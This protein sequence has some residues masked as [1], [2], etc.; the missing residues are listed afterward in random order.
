MAF[1]DKLCE[2]DD[3]TVERSLYNEYWYVMYIL[4]LYLKL[5]TPKWRLLSGVQFFASCSLMMYFAIIMIITA[6][7]LKENMMGM[8]QGLHYAILLFLVAAM[9]FSLNMCRPSMAR[10]HRGIGTGLSEYDME[11]EKHRAP[12]RQRIRNYQILLI[13]LYCIYTIVAIIFLGIIAILSENADESENELYIENGIS[14]DVPIPQWSPF[15]TDTTLKFL[16]AITLQALVCTDVALKNCGFN[17]V[18]MTVSLNIVLELD[19]LIISLDRL[20]QRALIMYQER[21][22]QESSS[23]VDMNR[24]REDKDLAKCYADCLKQNVQHHQ[25]IIQ[26]FNDLSTLVTDQ[27]FR[28][29]STGAFYTAIS[30]ALI[31]FAQGSIAERVASAAF[32]F[33]E[34]TNI[35]LHCW[36]AEQITDGSVRLSRALY[37]TNWI[38]IDKE[39]ARIVLIMLTRANLPLVMTGKNL[40]KINFET[41]A[42]IMNSAY[43]F[44]NLLNA[45]E[46]QK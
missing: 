36:C 14:L 30:G 9:A 7:K 18:N 8:C 1:L 19:L 33:A 29:L 13:K 6:V 10:I 45:V 20:P 44:F 24:I 23:K 5:N 17:V 34:I 37:S 38:L 2:E 27:M 4:G 32:C 43:S 11:T 28:A 21:H 26:M 31:M 12:L 3:P 42:N 15:S 40:V 22:G 16:L 41:F 46:E 35:F 39:N 25:R